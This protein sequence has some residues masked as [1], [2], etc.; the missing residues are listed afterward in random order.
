MGPG[1]SGVVKLPV[2]MHE[3]TRTRALGRCIRDE[4]ATRVFADGPAPKQGSKVIAWGWIFP[5]THRPV[6]RRRPE[7]P[8]RLQG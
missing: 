6:T 4:I 3:G 1:F 8:H 7:T 2:W 5:A